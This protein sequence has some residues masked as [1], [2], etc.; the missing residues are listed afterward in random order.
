MRLPR[1]GVACCGTLTIAGLALAAAVSNALPTGRAWSSVD[2]VRVPGHTR[3]FVTGAALDS[4]GYP[5][6][7][8]AAEG[9]VG[10]DYVALGWEDSAWVPRWRV[11]YKLAY[12]SPTPDVPG[13]L[14]GLVWV[15]YG[16]ERAMTTERA[17]SPMLSPNF[18]VMSADQGS[19]FAPPDTIAPVN[20]Y[21]LLISGARSD[22]WR[23]ALKGDYGVGMRLFSSPRSHEWRERVIGPLPDLVQG[24]LGTANESTVVAVW[25]QR[26]T[27]R[28]RW[29]ILQG[30]DWKEQPSGPGTG[31]GTTVV[32]IRAAEPGSVWVLWDEGPSD[33]AQMNLAQLHPLAAG[34]DSI[35][36]LRGPWPTERG[37]W[38]SVA[39]SFS[40]D[41]GRY[42][43]VVWTAYNPVTYGLSVAIPSGGGQYTT[44]YIP[45]ADGVA[46]ARI[47]RDVNDDVWLAWWNI[48]LEGMFCMHTV[49]R[50]TATNMRV[51]ARGQRVDLSWSLTEP[52]PGSVWSIL[53]SSDGETYEA[54]GR[55]RAGATTE[56]R[57]STPT[58]NW[59]SRRGALLYRVRRE[60][61]D[62][63]YEWVSEPVSAAHG[64]SDLTLLIGPR[65][66]HFAELALS[67]GGAIGPLDLTVFDVQGRRILRRTWDGPSGSTS[68]R[69]SLDEGLAAGI[70]FVR[71][72]DADG[73]TATARFVFL[74]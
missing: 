68:M 19:S 17:Q 32:S 29:G 28:L 62:K 3:L 9:G 1:V 41:G 56:M 52:A 11:G 39:G 45:E 37:P 55:L 64:R 59:R 58:T 61:V 72:S 43:V 14:P 33:A 30:S 12:V 21:S 42:P 38:N 20:A 15:A 18:L 34:W 73:A 24:A 23:W 47:V 16:S 4:L 67:V 40:P 35:T 25:P 36:T 44:E 26:G 71:L 53:R 10:S 2:T 49:V 69:L 51:R 60:A 5:R 74:R 8:A 22:T 63:R 31:W 48:E 54:V 46:E 66:P 50:A 6:F 7:Y 57:W 13:Q 65:K 27:Y 70:Y